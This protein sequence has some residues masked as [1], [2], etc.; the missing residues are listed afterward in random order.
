MFLRDLVKM[1]G[2]FFRKIRSVVHNLVFRR[3]GAITEVIKHL[4]LYRELL[5][6]LNLVIQLQR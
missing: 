5:S 4:S 2:C 3:V 1:N 6:G